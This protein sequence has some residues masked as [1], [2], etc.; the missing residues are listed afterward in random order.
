MRAGRLRV[1]LSDGRLPPTAIFLVVELFEHAE[2]RFLR[3]VG[4]IVRLFGRLQWW[5]RLFRRFIEQHA[6]WRFE[7][8][9]EELGRRLEWRRLVGR[10]VLFVRLPRWRQSGRR[11]FRRPEWRRRVGWQLRRIARRWQSGRWLGRRIGWFVRRS[12]RPVRR[13]L[14]FERRTERFV[15]SEC[16]CRYFAPRRGFALGRAAFTEHGRCFWW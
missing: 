12:Q 9:L 3:F 10:R 8:W 6:Q 5:R 16:H 7:R 15:G 1:R 14:G 11:F 2:R 4:R 13:S